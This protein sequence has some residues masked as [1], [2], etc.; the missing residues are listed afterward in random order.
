MNSIK[1]VVPYAL[2]GNEK[3]IPNW[4]DH[5]SWP[6]DPQQ[7][8][9]VSHRVFQRYLDFVTTLPDEAKDIILLARGQR[10]AATLI[11]TAIAL[12]GE[13]AHNLLLSGP[14]TLE[15]LRRETPIA[16]GQSPFTFMGEKHL[17]KQIR[18]QRLRQIARIRSWST[19]PGTLLNF[20]AP[21]SLAITYNEQ[22]IAAARTS[23]ARLGFVHAKLLL[24]KSLKGGQRTCPTKQNTDTLHNLAKS[25]TEVLLSDPLLSDDEQAKAQAILYP[26]I[27]SELLFSNDILHRLR[28]ARNLPK[29]VWSGSGGFFPARALGLE[30]KRRGGTV[31]RFDHG[32]T[33]SLIE[34]PAFH[35]H[36]DFVVS[37]HAYM[38]SNLA[39]S[40]PTVQRASALANE[41]SSVSV[42]GGNGDPSL[43]PPQQVTSAPLRTKRIMYVSG[44][45]YGYYQACPPLPAGPVYLDW[46]HRLFDIMGR[47]SFEFI[48]KPHP[49]G[50]FHGHPP[51]LEE[52]AGPNIKTDQ[53]PFEQAIQDIDCFVFDF[54][55]TTTFS[56]ALSTN[57]PIILLD[58]CN[59]TF[60]EGVAE[61]I[62]KRC[63]I[64][65]VDVDDRNR[66]SVTPERIEQAIVS[67]MDQEHTPS[68]FRSLFL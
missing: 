9:A 11:E 10:E 56:I 5:F 64:V 29:D 45:Y 17:T 37:T 18:L 33:M 57:K 60:A 28:H 12:S 2:T 32:G 59:V 31:R 51:G 6:I 42:L 52:R 7:T 48:H 55:A 30:V 4:L 8:M 44:A 68:F 49:G 19:L 16:T 24:E 27:G 47:L 41:I 34:V 3:G 23:R 26:I 40:M 36:Q 1:H 58:I 61:E 21:T 67:S 22:L 43:K 66:L 20:L 14:A 15:N 53:R 39:A 35:A 54:T 62:R 46:Q 25:Y 13:H 65:K 63:A 50:L 38:P